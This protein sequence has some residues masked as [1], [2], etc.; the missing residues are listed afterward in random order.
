M[1]SPQSGAFISPWDDVDQICTDKVIV[2]SNVDNHQAAITMERYDV[3]FGSGNS[4]PSAQ[5]DLWSRI[6]QCALHT[7]TT[8]LF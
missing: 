5:L 2:Q 7:D 4:G 8:N 3:T 1:G 6:S